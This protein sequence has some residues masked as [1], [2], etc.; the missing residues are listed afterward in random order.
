LVLAILFS[1]PLFSVDTYLESPKSHELGLLMTTLYPPGTK[2]FNLSF[3]AY[4]DL[5]SQIKTPVFYA[6]ISYKEY[7]SYD[8]V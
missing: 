3:D 5:E 7:G 6:N 2:A 1:V 4:I 8:K